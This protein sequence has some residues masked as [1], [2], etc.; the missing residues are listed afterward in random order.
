MYN[1]MHR[2]HARQDKTDKEENSVRSG[3]VQPA[4]YLLLDLAIAT[5]NF[6]DENKIGSGG[7]GVVYKG[8]IGGQIVAIKKISG[9]SLQLLLDINKEIS[10]LS[11]FEN[12]NLVKLLGFCW[13]AGNYLLVSHCNLLNSKHNQVW[14]QYRAKKPLAE[15]IDRCLW[16]KCPKDQVSR[17]IQIGLLCVQNNCQKRPSMEA[18]LE[19]LNSKTHL[20]TPS[21]P[22]FFK[23]SQRQSEEEEEAIQ[24]FRIPLLCVQHNRKKCPDMKCVMQMLYAS[25]ASSNTQAAFITNSGKHRRSKFFNFR[26]LVMRKFELSCY[27]FSINMHVKSRYHSRAFS[28]KHA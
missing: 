1:H 12:D 24:C 8:I 5:N 17:C 18:V 20:P 14:K 22:A 6:S 4:Q 7:F 19:M 23:D 2:S 10:L 27:A 28:I 25:L 13:E 15:V 26:S 11:F 16:D 9:S 21:L 3:A